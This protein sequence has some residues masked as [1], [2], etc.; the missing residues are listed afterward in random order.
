MISRKEIFY[1]G[2]VSLV[3]HVLAIL[4]FTAAANLHS[5]RITLKNRP[6]LIVSL[7]TLS[8]NSPL[9]VSQSKFPAKTI[10][11]ITVGNRTTK[12][13]DGPARKESTAHSLPPNTVKIVEEPPGRETESAAAHRQTVEKKMALQASSAEK[14][15][16]EQGNGATFL[17]DSGHASRQIDRAG[18]S[19][20]SSLL[21][22][23]RYQDTPSPEYP[24]ASRQRGEE[25]RVL[26]SVEILENGSA[27]QL[28]LKRSSGYPLLDQAALKA[29]RKCKFHPAVR[30]NVRIRSWGDV[31]IRFKL[32]DAE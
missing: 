19:G 25:G 11:Q 20:K 22:S 16:K 8:S 15:G 30:N 12:S 26:I 29:V 21:A 9:D 32:E 3:L 13:A 17:S 24:Y 2:T 23:S 10:G 31:P 5:P 27:G 6:E 14:S 7:A 28:I 4:L 18:E 1:A